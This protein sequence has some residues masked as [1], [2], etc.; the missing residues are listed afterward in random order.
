MHLSLG[1]IVRLFSRS[2]YALIEGRKTW[3]EPIQLTEDASADL[4]FWLDNINSRNGF[5]FK[6]RPT[7]SKVMFT[8]ASDTGYGGFVAERLN[9]VICVG[10]F[11]N[12]E[13]MESSTS[14]ELSAVK[15]VLQSF[16]HIIANESIQVNIDNIGACRILSVGSS[17]KH[18]QSLA[19]D[20]FKH[21]V[22]FNINLQPNW[23]PRD[24][25]QISD[26][27]SKYNDTDN[28]SIDDNSFY[29]LSK[30]FGPFSIDRFADNNNKK[31]ERFN[32]KFYCP[33]TESVNCFTNDW[34][35]ENNFLCPP[36]SLIGSTIRH[37]KICRASGTLVVPVWPSS[38][39]WPII[40]PNGYNIA[41]FV[42]RF[43]VFDP[44]FTS[45][46]KNSVFDGFANFKTLALEIKF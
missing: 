9:K 21:C 35:G 40:Y 8:D 46:C 24:M 31:T 32:S 20:V 5:T 37:L 27:Y 41:T 33:N 6:P 26:F 34:K 44:F 45:T 11:S 2:L 1:P 39:F 28:W 12:F 43:Y 42:K 7:T 23:V 30:R 4:K 38:Y 19:V 16:G 15:Y 29:T 22:K 3:Y 36:I 18:L 14:R 25:N 17:K 13:K 10:K